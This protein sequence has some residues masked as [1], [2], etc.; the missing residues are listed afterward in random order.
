MR[1]WILRVSLMYLLFFFKTRAASRSAQKGLCLCAL[2]RITLDRGDTNGG[3][4]P[5]R[6]LEKGALQG[7]QVWF[8]HFILY[9]IKSLITSSKKKTGKTITE[10]WRMLPFPFSFLLV[11][12]CVKNKYPVASCCVSLLCSLSCRSWAKLVYLRQ[13]APQGHVS[14]LTYCLL[15]PDPLRNVKKTTL[16]LVV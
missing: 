4:Q 13:L 7:I 2:I 10:S 15:D 5:W 16:F 14:G 12:H 8:F 1:R 6:C 9:Y 3:P 11:H